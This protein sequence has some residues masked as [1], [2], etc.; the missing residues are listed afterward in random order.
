[1]RV[2]LFLIILFAGMSCQGAAE[3]EQGSHPALSSHVIR[4]LYT[5]D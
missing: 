3:V 2:I 1:M 4:V 5:P